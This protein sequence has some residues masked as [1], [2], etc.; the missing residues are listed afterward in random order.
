VVRLTETLARRAVERAVGDRQAEY[1]EEMQRIVDATY[2]LIERTGGLDPSLRDILRETKL[3][4]QAF[5]KYFQSKDEL[6]LVLLDDGR[7]QLLDYLAH[8]MERASSDE[9]KLR[10]WIEGVLAQATRADVAARTRPFFANEDRLADAFPAEHQ[11]TIDLLI[12]QL[13]E[14][15]DGR[16]ARAVYFLTFGAL[17][18]H[19][20]GGTTPTEA[21]I[22]HIVQFALHGLNDG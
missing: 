22:Q 18:A 6:F 16:D 3:S 12:D 19:L 21:E 13:G 20:T 11:A 9:E 7:R 10:A 4:T 2:V 15:I 1:V 14:V 17:H 5:Y 8:R